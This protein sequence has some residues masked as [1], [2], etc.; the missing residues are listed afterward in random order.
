M[1]GCGDA[2][3]QQL[4]REDAGVCST[5]NGS[6]TNGNRALRRAPGDLTSI[7]FSSGIRIYNVCRAAIY[8]LA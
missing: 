2:S 7:G 8:K 1:G 5:F 3:G 6:D 4:L